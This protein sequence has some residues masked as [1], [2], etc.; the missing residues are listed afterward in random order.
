M[1]KSS[2]SLPLYCLIYFIVWLCLPSLTYS[3]LNASTKPSFLKNTSVGSRF[4]YGSYLTTKAK[5]EYIRDSYSYYG[6]VFIQHQTD[7]SEDWQKSHRLPKW[8]IAFLYGNS[9]SK[10]YIGRVTALYAYMNVPLIKTKRYTGS[11]LLGTGPCWVTKPYDIHLNPKNTLIGTHLNAFISTQLQNEIA[12]SDRLF[13]NAGISFIHFSNG[14]TT[15]PNLGLN[16]PSLFAGIRYAFN[17]PTIIHKEYNKVFSRSTDFKVFTTISLKQ[18]PS[19]GGNHYAINT[20]QVEAARR[21]TRN[22]SL[23]GGVH[24]FYNRSLSYFPLE[25]PLVDKRYG[26]KFQ[27]AT[28][29][30]YEH[31]FGKLSLPIQ[32]GVYI[33]NNHKSPLVYQQV[34]LRYAFSRH[35]SAELFLKSELGKAD[36]MHTGIGYIF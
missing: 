8:G 34:G 21:L 31:F 1:L 6:E 10:Q 16:I 32:A 27:I 28:Y 17:K 14:G 36:F 33:Y 3:Q 13:L 2:P 19:V 25:N 18:A 30:S 26:K 23:G 12:L 4:Y 11:F 5:A 7:G 35:W 24:F 22:Y 15:L 9:G 20:L 29:A